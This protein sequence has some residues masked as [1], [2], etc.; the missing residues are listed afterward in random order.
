M[1]LSSDYPVGSRVTMVDCYGVKPI[2]GV[3]IAHPG[4]YSVTIQVGKD[5]VSGSTSLVSAA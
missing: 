1:R 5:R 2:E 3:V 4:P